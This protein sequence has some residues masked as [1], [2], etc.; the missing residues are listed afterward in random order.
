[1]LSAIESYLAHKNIEKA[2]ILYEE[3]VKKYENP[4]EKIKYIYN[5]VGLL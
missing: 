3:T 2:V 5:F 4:T 1:M